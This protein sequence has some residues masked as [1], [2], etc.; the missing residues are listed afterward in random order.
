M[1]M[2]RIPTYAGTV[3]EKDELDILYWAIHKTPWERL[4]E[5]WRLHCVN[6]GITPAENKLNKTISKASKRP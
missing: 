4:Q 6:N 2:Q 5:S 1:K 3:S